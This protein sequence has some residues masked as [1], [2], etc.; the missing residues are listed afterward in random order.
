[1]R[2]DYP[3]CKIS[4][5]CRRRW[6]SWSRTASSCPIL[7]LGHPFWRAPPWSALARRIRSR[8]PSLDD[9]GCSV[10]IASDRARDGGATRRLR[11]A[12]AKAG[13]ADFKVIPAAVS[14]SANRR[15]ISRGPYVRLPDAPPAF[16]ANK[17]AR[18][19]HLRQH[20]SAE[21]V[22]RHARRTVPVLRREEPVAWRRRRLGCFGRVAARLI[23]L[24]GRG[25]WRAGCVAATAP[26][27]HLFASMDACLAASGATHVLTTPSMLSTIDP[28]TEVDPSGEETLPNLPNLRVVAL[29]GEPMPEALA[30][31]WLPAV[32]RLVNATA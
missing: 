12:W 21:G 5:A 18:V 25:A 26:R 29:G 22:P 32:Q 9:A 17:L 14:L 23:P 27:S 19:L 6:G 28:A 2:R 7:H 16:P 1:M 11:E 31:A 24:S 4:T 3:I 15:N 30:R 13:R 8:R 20:R 10:A